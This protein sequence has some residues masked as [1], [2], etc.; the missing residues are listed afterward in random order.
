MTEEEAKTKWCPYTT[1]GDTTE[2]CVGSGC[3]AWRWQP[4]MADEKFKT[5]II[6]AAVDI[7]DTTEGKTKAT[8]HVMANR[9]DYGLP[10]VPFDGFCGLAGKP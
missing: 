1:L 5:A 10:T 2:S 6:K 8:K 7:N 4:L 3:M 9:A